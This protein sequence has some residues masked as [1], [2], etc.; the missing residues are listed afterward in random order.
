MLKEDMVKATQKLL[1]DQTSSK[2]LSI[3]ALPTG[4]DTYEL[5]DIVKATQKLLEDQT[6][7][8]GFIKR[9]FGG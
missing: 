9:I 4:L 3:P 5:L 1:E 6:S 7:S 2:G 8:K